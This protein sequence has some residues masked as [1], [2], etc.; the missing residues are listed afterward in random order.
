MNTS[1]NA[2]EWTKIGVVSITVGIFAVAVGLSS[3]LL[4][5][6]LKG[7]DL[8]GFLI[9]AN[10][11]MMPIGLLSSSICVP[12]LAQRRGAYPVAIACAATAA[13]ALSLM[14]L[15]GSLVVWFPAR[16][17]LGFG[18]G[19]F[20]IVNKAWLNE[21]AVPLYRG[22]IMGLYTA[23]LAAGFSLGPLALAVTG[24]AGRLAFAVGVSAILAAALSVVLFA[25]KLPSFSVKERASIR[26]FVPL[27][28][29]LLILVGMFGFFDHATLAF[30]PAFGMNR[31][32]S[33]ATMA[34]GLALLNLGNVFLQIPIGWLADRLSR[35]LV[36]VGCAGATAVGACLLPFVAAHGTL[37]LFALLFVWGACAYGVTT[38]SLAE[39]GDRFSG[40]TLLAGSAAFTLASG[41]GGMFGGPVTGAAIDN[42]GDIGLIVTLAV[43]FG[44][45]AVLVSG[46]PLTRAS[47][48]FPR[49]MTY[50]PFG[51][52]ARSRR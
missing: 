47:A 25:R 9:G 11:A 17:A 16:F 35:R 14:G 36:L 40:S 50:S 5:L 51:L 46:L 37:P 8:S 38:V 3:P 39:L 6:V 42:L 45:L 29:L 22:R 30:L 33:E 10:A 20:Y 34:L 49:Q 1:P 2:P 48:Q 12:Q 23:T 21:I 43:G 44:V 32:L 18:I 41:A 13:L 27:A 52:G 31:G 28:P 26:S 24:S 15:V 19:G 4:A 7:Q